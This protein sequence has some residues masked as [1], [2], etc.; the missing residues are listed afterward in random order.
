MRFKKTSSSNCYL[1]TD[2]TFFSLYINYLSSS[3][4]DK[5]QGI[6]LFTWSERLLI[7]KLILTFALTLLVVLFWVST[8]SAMWRPIF[9]AMAVLTSP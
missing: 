5:G 8:G 6:D 7:V 3:D 2:L 9:I 1:C 4:V